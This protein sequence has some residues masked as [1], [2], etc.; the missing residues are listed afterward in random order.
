MSDSYKG[1]TMGFGHKS[2][3]FVTISKWQLHL[4]SARFICFA[5]D[6]CTLFS[7]YQNVTTLI[8]EW[9]QLHS[10]P[11]MDVWIWWL[12]VRRDSW[13]Y[14]SRSGEEVQSNQPATLSSKVLS[15]LF[16]SS[17]N[18]L[19]LINEGIKNKNRPKLVY[20]LQSEYSFLIT[21]PILTMQQESV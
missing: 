16:V 12:P 3:L 13:T 10:Q 18:T 15:I 7:Q 19:I 6:H 5:S 21:L 2:W 9:I 17:F 8:E 4:G 11:T 20:E 1:E 14:Q